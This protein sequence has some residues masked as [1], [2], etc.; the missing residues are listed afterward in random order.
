RHE[1]M[2]PN[3]EHT[4][5]VPTQ[6]PGMILAK[7]P[8]LLAAPRASLLLGP[9]HARRKSRSMRLVTRFAL[10]LTPVVIAFA[11]LA[12]T[13]AAEKGRWISLYNGKDLTGWSYS[14]TD[15]FEEKTEASDG[16]YTAKD[17]AIV[18]NPHDPAR[19]PKLRQMWT[20]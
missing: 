8:K 16:R 15:V 10:I 7:D 19:G 12:P 17:E 11:L 18:V 13:R 2:V 6:D 1:L 3:A 20:T 5:M 4:L 9:T 14:E